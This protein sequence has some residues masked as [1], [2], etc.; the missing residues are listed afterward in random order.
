M[1]IQHPIH[2]R[3]FVRSRPNPV[4]SS[5]FNKPGDRSRSV[6]HKGA[7]QGKEDKPCTASKGIKVGPKVVATKAERK[8]QKLASKNVENME[9]SRSAAAGVEKATAAPAAAPHPANMD[10]EAALPSRR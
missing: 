3:R 10:P 6:K 9:R 5:S 1:S 8:Q 2:S 4:Q 7:Q